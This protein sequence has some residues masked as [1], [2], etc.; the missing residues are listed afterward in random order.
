MLPMHNEKAWDCFWGDA[1]GLADK[2]AV[3]DSKGGKDQGMSY[4]W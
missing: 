1:Y 3:A 4:S 2:L